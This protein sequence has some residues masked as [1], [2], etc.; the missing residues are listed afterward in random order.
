PRCLFLVWAPSS[1]SQPA[2]PPPARRLDLSVSCS[3]LRSEHSDPIAP[4]SL[5]VSLSLCLLP[6]DLQASARMAVCPA[7]WR[8]ASR[9]IHA[10]DCNVPIDVRRNLQTQLGL[11]LAHACNARVLRPHRRPRRKGVTTSEDTRW[12]RRSATQPAT[13]PGTHRQMRERHPTGPRF[14]ARVQRPRLA[15]SPT[16]PERERYD[17]RRLPMAWPLRDAARHAAGQTPSDAREDASHRGGHDF[18]DKGV[19]GEVF[20]FGHDA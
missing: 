14:G 19:V 2:R 7:A 13:P 20:Y 8:A 6:F 9:S 10:P 18:C 11:G 17:Q 4:V 15:P 1:N 12:R 3:P 5:S 16:T